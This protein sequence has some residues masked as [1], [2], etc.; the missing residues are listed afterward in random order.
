M[1]MIKS[2]ALALMLIM[3]R[4][5]TAQEFAIKQ[6]ELTSESVVIHYDLLDTTK[7]RLYA[8]NVFTSKDDFLNPLARVKGDVGLEV[9]P[10]LNR[11]IAWDQKELGAAF[12]GDVEIEIRGKVYVP[13]VRFTNLNDYKAIKRGKPTTLTWTGGTRQNILNFNLYKGEELVTVISNVANSGDYDIVIPTSVKP[14]SG[15]YFIVSDSK[16]KD[17]VMK[18]SDFTVKRKMKLVFKVLP[19][20]VAGVIVY[21]LLPKPGP[22]PLDDPLGPPTTTN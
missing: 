10:G 2:S 12:K 17:L 15:Y 8:V 16:N 1:N 6:V 19:I 14:G 9:K 18:T 22:A 21:Q 5:A 7:N 13:F 20:V 11:R 4:L 3:V